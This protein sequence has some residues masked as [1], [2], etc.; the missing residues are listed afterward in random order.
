MVFSKFDVFS[1][2]WTRWLAPNYTSEFRL[3]IISNEFFLNLE[4]LDELEKLCVGL[5]AE[6]ENKNVESPEWNEHPFGPENL[7]V[8]G[9][10]V[11]VKD[12][13]N[14]NI[15]FPVPD[16]REHYATQV[17]YF[18]PCPRLAIVYNRWNLFDSRNVT[19]ATWLAM[20]DQAVCYPNWKIEDGST[21]LWL[22]KA[23]ELRDLPSSELTLT[24][25]KMELNMWII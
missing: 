23:A 4:S 19:L 7:Q 20:K 17:G 22:E 13:R 2:P 3:I 14:L 15:T 9:L 8:R 10:V 16:M 1:R 6:V 25:P 11:P 21:H 24:W 12:I 18:N 5:F